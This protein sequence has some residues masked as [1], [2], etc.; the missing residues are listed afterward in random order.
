M[1]KSMTGYGSSVLETAELQARVEL[2]SIN[3]KSLDLKMRIP[4]KYTEKEND[5]QSFI[6][7]KLDRGKIDL[8]ITVKFS[9]IKKNKRNINE[10]LFKAYYEEINSL[11]EIYHIPK[12]DILRSI[13]T[14]PDIISSSQE[15]NEIEDWEWKMIRDALMA[16]SEELNNSREKEGQKLAR[17]ILVYIESIEK[18]NNIIDA[19]K[20]NRIIK[21]REKID[22]RL[23]A[24]EDLTIDKERFEQELIYYLEKLDITEEIERLRT[25][26]A[27]FR[28]T[29]DEENSGRKL[30]FISQEMGR[31]IN[32]IGSKANNAEIQKMV[33]EM[34][35]ELEKVKQQLANIL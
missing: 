2:K 29:M 16:A 8:S 21:I 33:V 27:F 1:I 20:D 26:L 12:N 13:L 34:K 28:K 18:L 30:N 22:Q 3:S 17:E 25:H 5:I 4:L 32:T 11:A 19:Q 14:L 24:I 6:E 23:Q 9:D 15:T 10:Q 35:N 31:E 7:K